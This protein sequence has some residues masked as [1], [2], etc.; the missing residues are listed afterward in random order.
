[1]ETHIPKLMRHSK[2]S[3]K[4]FLTTLPTLKK[5]DL[6]L[7]SYTNNALSEKSNPDLMP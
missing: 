4:T 3:S 7:T 6:N 5:I 2:S 1:M